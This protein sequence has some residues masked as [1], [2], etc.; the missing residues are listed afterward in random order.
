MTDTW[1][2]EDAPVLVAALTCLDRDGAADGHEVADEAGLDEDLV[3]RALRR[4]WSGKY[5]VADFAMWPFPRDSHGLSLDRLSSISVTEATDRA[6]RASGQWPDPEALTA[7]VVAA[8]QRIE[9]NGHGDEKSRA[10][11]ILDALAGGGTT[12]LSEAL[13]TVTLRLSGM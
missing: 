2:T 9:E 6:R 7:D 13:A 10:R 1:T 3:V 11:K 12:V 8:L 4:L 5:L